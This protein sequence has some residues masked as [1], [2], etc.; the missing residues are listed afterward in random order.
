MVNNTAVRYSL[1]FKYDLFSNDLSF[2]NE[3]NHIF[4]YFAISQYS[5]LRHKEIILI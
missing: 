5:T 4:D 2:N 3:K 1:N